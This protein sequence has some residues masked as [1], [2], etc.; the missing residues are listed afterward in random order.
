MDG[1]CLPDRHHTRL[2][3]SSLWLFATV[4]D[5]GKLVGSLHRWIPIAK[6]CLGTGSDSCRVLALVSPTHQPFIAR[7]A[8]IGN[9]VVAV[10]DASFR[11]AHIRHLVSFAGRFR[12][13]RFS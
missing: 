4:A 2:D 8:G 3:K 9:G 11:V 1:L 13:D 10:V 12:R 5:R 7:S 6:T